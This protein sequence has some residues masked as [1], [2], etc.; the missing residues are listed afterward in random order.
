MKTNPTNVEQPVTD[1]SKTTKPAPT[2]PQVPYD[3]RIALRT[4]EAAQMLSIK[5]SKLRELKAGQRIPYLKIDGCVA[6]RVEDLKRFA[7]E[8]TIGNDQQQR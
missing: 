8:N 3:Q 5:Q 6:Y 7:S 4:P 2:H 1:A